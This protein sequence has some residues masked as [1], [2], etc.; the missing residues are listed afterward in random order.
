[1]ASYSYKTPSQIASDYIQILEIL[2]PE[3]NPIQQ[4]SDWWIR[5]NVVGG[6]V[7]GLYAD[8][9]KV[10]GDI[11][12]QTAR[13]AALQNFLNTYGLE[14]QIQ[15]QPADGNVSVTGTIGTIY[16]IGQQFQHVLSGN[17]YQAVSGVT[18]VSTTGSVP[19]QSVATGANQNLL[20]GTPLTISSPPA[21]STSNAIVINMQ[22]GRDLETNAQMAARI[23]AFIQQ[24]IS[25]GTKTD[26]QQW[27]QQGDPS[28]TYANVV[29][30]NAYQGPGTVGIFIEAGT[31]D[32]DNAINNN[33]PI[34]RT[35]STG[36]VAA[37]QTYID[38]VNPLTDYATVASVQEIQIPATAHVTYVAGVSD[39]TIL[40]GQ[41]LTALQLVQR[42][43]ARAL[44]K[45]PAGGVQ[46]ASSGFVL[47][48]QIEEVLDTNLSAGPYE[49]GLYAS[50]LLDRRVDWLSASGPN[51]MILPNQIV[52]PSGTNFSGMIVVSGSIP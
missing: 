44:Y 32:I 52:A 14:A 12:P 13:T 43:M 4:D 26:Y 48:S 21:G 6:V 37:V 23:L 18:L 15:P 24:P 10:E 5:A 41:T 29:A 2:R 3:L 50:L 17:I 11:F 20:P 31:T 33:I 36:V 1:M 35:P 51:L 45:T 38:G 16:S 28:V 25:G 30:N 7:S 27:A 47:A 46:I 34:V 9:Q 22:D 19:V 40:S 42:E 8:Q 49:T 39:S